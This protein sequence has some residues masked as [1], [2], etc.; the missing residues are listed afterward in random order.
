NANIAFSPDGQLLA[1]AAE[2]GDIALWDAASGQPNGRPLSGH[3]RQV[4]SVA[5]YGRQLIS[6]SID[7]SI[8][9]WSLDARTALGPAV[10]THRSPIWSLASSPDGKTAAAGGDAQLV[11]WDLT[12]RQ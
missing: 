3:Q 5:F 2:F 10:R 4:T 7:G 12:T 1:S 6:G 8:M 11:F 9:F